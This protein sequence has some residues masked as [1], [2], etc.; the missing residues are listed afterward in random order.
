MGYSAGL[1]AFLKLD[2]MQTFQ[3]GQCSLWYNMPEAFVLHDRE[4]CKLLAVK[5]M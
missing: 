5:K 2:S 4:I 3:E 1:G